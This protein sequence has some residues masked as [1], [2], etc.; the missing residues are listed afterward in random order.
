MNLGLN[1]KKVICLTFISAFLKTNIWT[2]D[3]RQLCKIVHNILHLWSSFLI[4]KVKYIYKTDQAD[5]PKYHIMF[6]LTTTSITPDLKHLASAV[7]AQW[8]H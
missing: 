1:S 5:R 4:D 7:Q 6:Q 8:S 2:C 3:R